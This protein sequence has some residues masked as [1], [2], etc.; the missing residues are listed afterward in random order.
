MSR[1]RE[2]SEGHDWIKRDGDYVEYKRRGW[3]TPDLKV[4]RPKYVV[5]SYDEFVKQY[6][7]MGNSVCT[8]AFKS[9]FSNNGHAIV[10]EFRDSSNDTVNFL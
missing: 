8:K 4:T 1:L 3:N 10:F 2:L 5:S 7:S 9:R 6:P